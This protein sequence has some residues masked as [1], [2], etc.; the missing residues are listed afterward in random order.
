MNIKIALVGNPNSGKTTMFNAL[1]GSSQYVGNW[2]G[3]TVEKKT[4]KLKGHN[5]V[6]IVDLPGIYSLSPYT[7]EEVISRNYIIDEKPNAIIN[8]VDS[9]NLE[10]NL[11]L[12]TQL[13]EIGI[14]VVIAL[15]MADM[16]RKK[17]DII[18]MEKLGSKFGCEVIETSALN[19]EG[20]EKAA[21]AAIKLANHKSSKSNKLVNCVFSNEVENALASI[22][23]ILPSNIE[24]RRWF[25]IKLFEKDEKIIEKMNLSNDK[26][27]S[28]INIVE[29]CE[30]ILGED[31]ESIITSER[32]KAIDIIK[33]DIFKKK[34]NQRHSTSDKIDNILTNKYLA[35]PIFALIMFLVY[36]I[37]ISTVGTMMT[38]WVNERLFGEI[39]PPLVENFLV[40]IG[41][42]EWLNSLILEG[43]IGGVGSV[44]GFLPQMLVLFTL[45][46]VLE[47]TGYMS[48]IA[49]IMDRIFSKF[50]LSGK[51][52]IPMLIGSGCSVPG[53][54]A[55]RT[56]E[57]E[58][59]RRITVITTSFIPCSAKLPI[60]ALIAGALF[61]GSM[62][63][64]PAAYF[65][66]VAA[67]IMSG[68]I[69]KKTSGFA[70]DQT[71][72]VMELPPYQMPRVK[73]ILKR[74]L[75]QGKH[76]VQ[77]A[78]TI[79]F[80]ASGLIW[81]LKTFSW[82]FEMVD[83]NDSILVSVG[84]LIAPIFE[85]I[86]FGNW[87]ST[88][89][90]LTGLV[91]KENVLSTFGVL[92]NT[93]GEVSENG[94][95]IWTNMQSIFTPLSAF[96]FL[97]FNL[98]CVPC[99]ASVGAISREMGSAK[100]TWFAVGYQTLFAYSL[101]LIIYQLGMLISGHGF[102][103]GTA[104][105]LAVLAFLLYMLFKPKQKSVASNTI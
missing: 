64:A 100:W 31:S 2:P 36:Y 74:T 53:I 52:I 43:I 55:S 54:M 49:F 62:L 34:T 68:I 45:L 48:R 47:T 88:V 19:G 85:P 102:G 65:I 9:T 11:Y 17:G 26:I 8:I 69:L 20:C 21:E 95:E 38:D 103:I 66:G 6:E 76:F 44:L 16:L 15:N 30:S 3:V 105:A 46:A 10:R 96:S 91:A 24:N 39:L 94:L 5:D 101:S 50:G 18:D 71:P 82:T 56:I 61:N 80:L 79:I 97:V 42:A 84:R 14:P 67:I 4:G 25:S 83:T 33:K 40:S 59:D 51:S 77:K 75:D 81:F 29:S 27:N 87:Q 78:G 13:V 92:F 93:A 22:N 32:Y 35:L 12:T 104:V 86:G 60:I 37:S 72:F 70:G 1:T 99:F 89:A 57:S 73:D 28:I 63:I 98:I 90:T 23:E 7:L 58:S 41:T